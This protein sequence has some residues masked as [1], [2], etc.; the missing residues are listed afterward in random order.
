MGF[1]RKTTAGTYRA[2]WRDPS[3]GQR[4]KSFPTKR[5]ASRFLAEVESA[6]N[7]GLY[8]DPRAGRVR[9]SDYAATW[10]AGRASATTTT[11]RT[12]S[13]LRTH[14]LPRWG[15]VPLDKIDHS[16]VQRWVSELN[17]T[18]SPATVRK[19]FH[20]LAGIMRLAVRDRLL[21]FNPCEGVQLPAIRRSDTDERTISREGFLSQLLPVIPERHRALVALAGGTG[22]RWGECAGLRWDAVDLD[23]EEVHVVRV[24]VEVAGA[25][26]TKPFP[27]SRAGRRVVP[28]PPFVVKALRDHRRRYGQGDAGEVFTNQAG[29]PVRRTL[30][31]VRVW[32]P[33]L[34]RA[35]LLGKVVQEGES[36]YRGVWQDDAGREQTETFETEAAAVKEVSRRATGGLRFHDLRHSYATWL[37]S[38]GVP[39]NDVQRVMGHE[40][41]TTTLNL[42]THDSGSARTRVRGLFDAFSLPRPADETGPGH[43]NSS[44]D[45]L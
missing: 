33:A 44:E 32:R 31:R 22:L 20:V 13:V 21:A 37:V 11:V 36:V 5:E 27:K 39:V 18:R 15:P 41:A 6:K 8:V 34:V 3:G 7:H 35:G 29:G 40:Q 1:V 43:E 30:F 14:V 19:C 16:S 28:L 24:A 38:D 10:V 2:S 17:A 12:D 9:L 25:V 26:T 23:A 4:S 42:Y 45:D